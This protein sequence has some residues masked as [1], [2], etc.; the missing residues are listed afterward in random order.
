VVRG[1]G[2]VGAGGRCAVVLGGKGADVEWGSGM[3]GVLLLGAMQP[4]CCVG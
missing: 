4:R 1:V 2:W 3:I